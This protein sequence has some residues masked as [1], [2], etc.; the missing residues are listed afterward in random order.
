MRAYAR[1]DPASPPPPLLFPSCVLSLRLLSCTLSSF[2]KA[3]YRTIRLFA[4]ILHSNPPLHVWLMIPIYPSSSGELFCATMSSRNRSFNFTSR[5]QRI[6][7]MSAPQTAL[8]LSSSHYYTSASTLSTG[9]RSFPLT[10]PH[11]RSLNTIL[12]R[13]E[14]RP[15]VGAIPN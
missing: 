1:M 14:P 11:N 5:N 3:R 6:S 2:M 4:C 9:P 7:T 10:T 13:S 15:P 8:V 12:H